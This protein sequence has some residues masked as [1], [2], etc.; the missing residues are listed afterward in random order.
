MHDL[1]ILDQM[2]KDSAKVKIESRYQKPLLVL[3]EPKS[4]YSVEICGL[5]DNAIVINADAFESPKSVF[6][7]NKGE[8]KRADFIV[9]ADMG[10][11]KV[12][13]IIEMKRDKDDRNKIE[14]QLMGAKCFLAYCKEIGK[15]FW[16][17]KDFLSGYDYRFVCINRINLAKR[18]T[19]PDR[20]DCLHD[21]PGKMMRID[22]SSR[23]QFNK[24]VG[25][26][27]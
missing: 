15:S 17:E 21:E 20:E 19:R 9:V 22:W 25:K 18:R 12:I 27:D 14:K 26:F 23:L 13:I 2:I 3:N 7:G 10:R 16:N 5:P 6:N 11:N 4:D 8:C 24:L 1:D